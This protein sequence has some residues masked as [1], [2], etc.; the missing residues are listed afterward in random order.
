MADPT[1]ITTVVKA[2]AKKAG[3]KTAKKKKKKKAAAPNV[4]PGIN[5]SVTGAGRAS[6]AAN[7]FTKFTK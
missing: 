4:D 2:V 3:E 5:T 1:F 6:L 7:P